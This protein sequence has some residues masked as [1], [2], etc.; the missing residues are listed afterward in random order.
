[1]AILRQASRFPVTYQ[2]SGMFVQVVPTAF[3]MSPDPYPGSKNYSVP[4]HTEHQAYSQL[5]T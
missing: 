3:S 2:S 4:L 1:M 5:K